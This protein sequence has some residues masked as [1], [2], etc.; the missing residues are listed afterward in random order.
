MPRLLVLFPLL[1]TAVA[2]A[3]KPN[4][5]L[6]FADDLGRYASAYRDPQRP[7]P[8]DLIETPNFDRV[9]R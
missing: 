5:V 3:K 6:A 7:G 8:N 4:L 9:A 2:V 1:L